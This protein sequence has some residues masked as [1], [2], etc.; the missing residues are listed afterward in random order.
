[1]ADKTLTPRQ[2]RFVQEYLVDLNAT[3]AAI[4]AGYSARTAQ[5]Q[6]SR[7]LSNAIVQ[8]AIQA[9]RKALSQRT[10]VTQDRVVLELAHVAFSD[11]TVYDSDDRGKVVLA[12]G[13]DREAVR[14]IASVK[15][16]RRIVPGGE[17]ACVEEVEFRLWN[18]VEALKLLGQHLG[19]FKEKLELSGSVG[20]MGRGATVE[21]MTSEQ[22]ER[23][24]RE[25]D[26]SAGSE[27]TAPEAGGD[28]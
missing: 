3:Q 23:I 15:R 2:E 1:M 6:S 7:L 10:E 8:A 17:G 16:K 24:A 22:L 5:E 21:D 27:G 19:M 28:E 20:G 9:G 4:R 25:S 26:P 11:A 14:A 12:D 18:K 13:T